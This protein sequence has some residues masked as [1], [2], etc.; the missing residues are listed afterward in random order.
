ML[1]KISGEIVRM[2][3]HFSMTLLTSMADE[4][5][6]TSAGK[7]LSRYRPHITTDSPK[8]NGLEGTTERAISAQ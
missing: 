2:L 4:G 5:A 3:M 8:P 6:R 1:W 7:M